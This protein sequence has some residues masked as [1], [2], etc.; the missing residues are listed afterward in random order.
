MYRTGDLCRWT[1]EGEIEYVGRKDDQV[2]VNGYRIE[3]NEV[4]DHLKFVQGAEVLKIDNKLVAFVTPSDVDVNKVLEAA[5]TKLPHYMIPS[6]IVP[7]DKFPLTGNG[8]VDKKALAKMDLSKLV[9]QGLTSN[10]QKVLDKWRQVISISIEVKSPFASFFSLGGN[11]LNVINLVSLLKKDYPD[12][13]WNA[14]TVYAHPN[15]RLLSRYIFGPEPE[16]NQKR[17]IRLRNGLHENRVKIVCLHGQATSNS[18]FMDQLGEIM[19]SLRN[20]AHF[21]FIQAPFQVKHSHLELLYNS[22]WYEWWPSVFIMNRQVKR[23]IDHVT[24]ELKRI[25]PVDCLLGFSQGASVVEILDRLAHK[26][27]LEK[28]WKLSILMS[29]S[30][31]DPIQGL[32]VKP[33][34]KT[35]VPGGIPSPALIVSGSKNSSAYKLYFQGQEVDFRKEKHQP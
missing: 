7:L 4:R 9:R 12:K 17:T 3:L 22:K 23:S 8:K 35:K 25:G 6:L 33:K 26:Q 2:K 19:Y 30:G 18:V 14:A 10:E 21:E 16:S 27:K 31:I 24:S 29:G 11:S 28:T 1:E 5:M 20:V 34:Y 32:L 13:V 15:L